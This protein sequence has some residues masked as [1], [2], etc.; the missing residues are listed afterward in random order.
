MMFHNTMFHNTTQIFQLHHRSPS[1][2][3][4]S[5]FTIPAKMLKCKT[6]RLWLAANLG[7]SSKRHSDV[8]IQKLPFFSSAPPGSESP[9]W[10][11]SRVSG[12]AGYVASL[13]PTFSE[14]ITTTPANF[15]GGCCTNKKWK[16]WNAIC[17]YFARLLICC[18]LLF[19][20][21]VA[22][23]VLTNSI[24]LCNSCRVSKT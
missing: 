7:V 1:V 5:I 18:R 20:C 8:N 23:F 10:I 16:F 12:S 13:L 17:C 14:G 19:G 2:I 15:R 3:P 24:V 9:N 4:Q 21:N 11:L 6:H 22:S